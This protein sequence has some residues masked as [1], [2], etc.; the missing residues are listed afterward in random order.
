MQVKR[1]KLSDMQVPIAEIQ[2]PQVQVPGQLMQIIP[3]GLQNSG[4]K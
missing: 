3:L 2:P 4:K 1:P